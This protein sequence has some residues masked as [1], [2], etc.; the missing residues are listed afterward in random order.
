[1]NN[2]KQQVKEMQEM[3]NLRINEMNVFLSQQELKRKEYEEKIE[4]DD[5]LA[6][7]ILDE[8]DDSFEVVDERTSKSCTLIRENHDDDEDDLFWMMIIILFEYLTY[9]YY[10]S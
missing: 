7:E 8:D 3:T 6:F 5:T 10:H 4:V 2:M 1:M 9:P